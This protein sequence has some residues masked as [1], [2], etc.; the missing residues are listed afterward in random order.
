MTEQEK[1]K[2]ELAREGLEDIVAG[3]VSRIPPDVFEPTEEEKNEVLLEF[4]GFKFCRP[5]EGGAIDVLDP[6]GV[7][8]LSPLAKPNFYESLDAQ[9]KWLWPT[10]RE[11]YN[12]PDVILAVA[13]VMY[14]GGVP[15]AAALADAIYE[16]VRPTTESEAG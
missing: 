9:A 4:A 5:V 10:V 14:G 12:I 11:Q 6:D 3:R 8:Y 13:I 16:V 2:E 1:T 7:L 15:A